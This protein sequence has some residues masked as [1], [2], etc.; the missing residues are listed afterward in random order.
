MGLFDF[1]KSRKVKQENSVL[2]LT[3][4]EKN[5]FSG[6]SDTPLN[7]KYTPENITT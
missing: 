2:P 5:S 7:A 6:V 1:F 4:K 3:D